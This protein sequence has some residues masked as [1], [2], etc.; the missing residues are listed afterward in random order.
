M[1]R[2]KRALGIEKLHILFSFTKYSHKEHIPDIEMQRWVKVMELSDDWDK[3]F[4]GVW[5]IAPFTHFT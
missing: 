2:Q 4:P 3:L 1:L 5:S